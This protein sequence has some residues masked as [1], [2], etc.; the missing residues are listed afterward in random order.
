MRAYLWYKAVFFATL[1]HTYAL[2]HNYSGAAKIPCQHAQHA[3]I[4]SS[5]DLYTHSAL[6]FLSGAKAPLLWVAKCTVLD[7]YCKVCKKRDK[8]IENSMTWKGEIIIG[9]AKKTCRATIRLFVTSHTSLSTLFLWLFSFSENLC[10]EISV[11]CC[12]VILTYSW[13][14]HWIDIPGGRP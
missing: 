14:H 10:F 5:H 4:Y 8:Y 13:H 3:H 2:H 12:S 6:H 7:I 1:L 11:L 9:V